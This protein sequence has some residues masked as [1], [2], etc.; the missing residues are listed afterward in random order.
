MCGSLGLC[1][2]LTELQRVIVCLYIALVP[3]APN[4]IYWVNTFSKR[5][6]PASQELSSK[7]DEA[8]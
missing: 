5:Q 2:K 6:A 3:K 1:G 4:Q 8:E 7:I